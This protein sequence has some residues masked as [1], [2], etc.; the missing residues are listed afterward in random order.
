M[1]KR[2]FYGIPDAFSFL[3]FLRAGSGKSC[4]TAGF[5]NEQA[6]THAGKPG[7]NDFIRQIGH[8]RH[9]I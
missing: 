1:P 6:V 8:I 4:M 7:K 2:C 5:I 3:L 9:D